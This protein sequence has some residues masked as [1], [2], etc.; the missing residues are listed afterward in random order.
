MESDLSK[1]NRELGHYTKVASDNNKIRTQALKERRKLLIN[2]TTLEGVIVGALGTFSQGYLNNNPYVYIPLLL[3]LLGMIVGVFILKY[4]NEGELKLASDLDKL[5]LESFEK[6]V[7]DIKDIALI[8]IRD[9][10]IQNRIELKVKHP[11]ADFI[12]KRI[13]ADQLEILFYQI[14]FITTFLLPLVLSM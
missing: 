3:Y 11:I 5:A 2:I 1:F 7:K 14:F 10:I 4:S 9:T 6:G 12:F 8:G 13:N